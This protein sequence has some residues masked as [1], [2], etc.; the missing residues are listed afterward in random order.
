MRRRTGVRLLLILLLVF[1]PACRPTGEAT[2]ISVSEV[3]S[4]GRISQD[5]ASPF[6]LEQPLILFEEQPQELIWVTGWAVEVVEVATGQVLPDMLSY[7]TLDFREP[8]AHQENLQASQGTRLFGLGRGA[9]SLKFPRGFGIPARSTEALW[10]SSGLV[11][12]ELKLPNSEFVQRSLI[13][14]TRERGLTERML[15]LLARNSTVQVDEQDF[16]LVP[17]GGSTRDCDLTSELR[18]PNRTTMHA[19][20]VS[21]DKWARKIELWDTTE[22]SRLLSLTTVLNEATGD[23]LETQTYSDHKGILFDPRHEYSVKVTYDNPSEKPIKAA[24]HLTVYF[25][26]HDFSVTAQ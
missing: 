26:D 24:A 17:P 14:L 21:L 2:L 25:Y 20:T 15:P 1:A 7:T 18:V 11:N 3:V 10:W 6:R 23:I 22:Q 16:W 9:P 12:P 4:G 13:N 8:K 5:S 19:V